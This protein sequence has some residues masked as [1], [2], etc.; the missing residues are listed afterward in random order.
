MSRKPETPESSAPRRRAAATPVEVVGQTFEVKLRAASLPS[1][2]LV[3]V[4]FIGI[5]CVIKW[6]PTKVQLLGLSSTGSVPLMNSYLPSPASDYTGVNESSP[7]ADGNALYYAFANFGNPVQVSSNGVQVTTFRFKAIA[8]FQS[9]SVEI[10]PSYTVRQRADTVV[11][12]GTVPGLDVLG[13]ISAATVTQ[14]PPCRC[15]LDGDGIVG[16]G[17]LGVMLNNWGAGGSGDFD[18]DGVV[19]GRDL[20][21]LLSSWGQSTVN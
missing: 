15:D 19:N 5:D 11:Y 12:D 8:E 6:D 10:L 21:V 4:S 18:G 13:A 9:S 16:G 3:G 7:P 14:A 20:G 17:D 1:S 2:N